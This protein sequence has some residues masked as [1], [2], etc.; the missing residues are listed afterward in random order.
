MLYLL[1]LFKSTCQELLSNWSIYLTVLYMIGASEMNKRLHDMLLV[2]HRR[3]RKGPSWLYGCWFT[4]NCAI[5]AYHHWNCK[6]ESGSWWGVLDTTLCDKVCRW[7]AAGQWFSPGNPVS[8]TNKTDCHNILKSVNGANG[9]VCTLT[10][11]LFG[12]IFIHSKIY[13]G[14]SNQ[15]I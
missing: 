1:K 13:K 3:K 10:G 5:S 8:S 4:T 7:F 9:Y 14:E 15:S 2:Y 12:Y 6:L 11:I